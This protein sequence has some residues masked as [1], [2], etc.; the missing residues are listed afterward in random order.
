MTSDEV[1]ILEPAID[2]SAAFGADMETEETAA[3]LP[4]SERPFDAATY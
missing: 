2:V 4:L 1:A 3:L